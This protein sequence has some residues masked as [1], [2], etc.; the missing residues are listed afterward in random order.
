MALAMTLSND[1]RSGLNWG[2]SWDPNCY[3]IDDRI[4]DPRG[5]RI[6]VGIHVRIQG[7]HPGS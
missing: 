3:P 1:P 7:S 5:G 4:H 2:P 6:H